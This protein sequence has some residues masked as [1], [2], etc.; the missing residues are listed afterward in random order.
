MRTPL[1]GRKIIK[2]GTKL[3]QRKRFSAVE[4]LKAERR[5]VERSKESGG[6]TAG[7]G[8]STINGEELGQV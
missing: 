8:R 1:T 3:G 7:G 4:K 6:K 5:G 2:K